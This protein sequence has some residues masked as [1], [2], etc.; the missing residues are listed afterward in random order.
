M[1]TAI[2]SVQQALYEFLKDA[3]DEQIAAQNTEHDDELELAPLAEWQLGFREPYS[4]SRFPVGCLHYEESQPEDFSTGQGLRF[5]STFS[6]V[7]VHA[8]GRGDQVAQITAR[9]VDAILS[10]W[11]ADHTFGGLAVL[12]DITRIEVFPPVT[13]GRSLGTALVTLNLITQEA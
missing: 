1:I 3:I 12:S 5:S 6:I 11:Q 9:Y 4:G 8:Q 10:V 2:Y 13:S 7:L